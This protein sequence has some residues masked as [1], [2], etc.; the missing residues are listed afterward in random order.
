MFGIYR[1]LLALL[2]VTTHLYGLF[3]NGIYAVFGFYLLSGFLMTM[4]MHETYGY[5]LPGRWRYLVNRFL[6]IFPPYWAAIALTVVL[7]LVFG[8]GALTRFHRA[9]YLPRTAGEI[10]RNVFLVFQK[11]SLPR[12]SPATW[13]LTVEL[14]YYLLICLGISAT[15]RRAGAWAAAS[16]LYT[17]G[18]LAFAKRGSLPALTYSSILA[19]SLPFSLGSFLYFV[20][21]ERRFEGLFRRSLLLRPEALTVALLANMTLFTALARAKKSYTMLGFTHGLYVN[22][23]IVLLLTLSLFHGKGYAGTSARWDKAIGDFSYPVYLL[24]WQTGFLTSIAVVGR[25]FHGF[26]GRG[27]QNLLVAI[28][29]VLLLSFLFI[30]AIDGPINRLRRRVKA[31]GADEGGR[32]KGEAPLAPAPSSAQG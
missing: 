7:I 21:R 13:A 30:R 3:F 20:A 2:V 9:I 10:L 15:R 16:V 18:A 26:G 32:A 25:P 1:T 4:I 28:P 31:A 12:L 17:A 11:D 14:T 27:L 19:G 24:H 5:T 8:E 22:L 29:A 23:A 6:R